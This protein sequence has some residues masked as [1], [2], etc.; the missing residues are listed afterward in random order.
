[1]ENSKEILSIKN[2]FKDFKKHL[3]SYFG[4]YINVDDISDKTLREYYN[5]MQTNVDYIN[6]KYVEFRNE[7]DGI[8]END[9]SS[10]EDLRASFRNVVKEKLTLVAKSYTPFLPTKNHWCL[11]AIKSYIVSLVI[12]SENY[13]QVFGKLIS[14]IHENIILTSS[15]Q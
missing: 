9:E 3:H 12:D 8:D 7:M 13:R 5:T 15:D 6:N 4:N 14:E 10:L 1:M 11:T 2:T